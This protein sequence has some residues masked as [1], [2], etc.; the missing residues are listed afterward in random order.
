MSKV[1][2]NYGPIESTAFPAI[3]N[4]VG[5][6]D[7]ATRALQQSSIPGDFYR[8]TTLTNTISNLK[9]YRSTL[10]NTKTWLYDSNKNYDSMIDKL[11]S[12]AHQLPVYEVKKRNPIV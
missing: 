3:D 7:E 10:A 12:Q 9:S 8:K 5:Y 1:S 6:L 2:L 11:S 4:V